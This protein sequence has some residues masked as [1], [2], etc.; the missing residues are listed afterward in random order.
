M[1]RDVRIGPDEI[2]AA[3]RH[4]IVA[5]T[6]VQH[7]EMER[8]RIKRIVRRFLLHGCQ[9]LVLGQ[10]AHAVIAQY[11]VFATGQFLQLLMD[12]PYIF[13][14]ALQRVRR[15]NQVTQFEH[16]FD[17]R[18]PQLFRRGRHFTRRLAIV[19]RAIGCAIRIVEIGEQ[20]D[21]QDRFRVV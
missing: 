17:R 16:Q 6:R 14:F 15:V 9:K 2:L 12:G 13:Q 11:V 4:S 20:A 1:R 10:A 19:P 21:P 8:T 5:V 7:D 18:L 3:V